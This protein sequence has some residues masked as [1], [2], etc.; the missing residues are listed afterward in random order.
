MKS[1]DI[2][3]DALES[4]LGV[5]VKD[6]AA[7]MS[8]FRGLVSCCEEDDGMESESEDGEEKQGKGQGKGL[9]GALILP[10]RS[11]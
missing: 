5:K 4:A 7:F 8:A 11:K 3:L 10:G 6:R 9:L 2:H 1:H